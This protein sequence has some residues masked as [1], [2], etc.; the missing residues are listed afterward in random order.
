ML[1]QMRNEHAW[2]PTLFVCRAGRW[3]ASLS[4]VDVAPGSRVIA[5][6]AG[7]AYADVCRR[8]AHGD[9]LDLGCGTVPCYEMYRDRVDTVTCT[10]WLQS[11]HGSRHLDFVSDLTAELPLAPRTFDTVVLT[12]VLEHLP[13]PDVV[14][15]EMRRVL[16]PGGKAIIAVPFL[17]WIHEQPHDFFRYTEHQLRR[18]CEQHDLI[19]R[20][21][22]AYG[23][24]SGVLADVLLKLLGRY[25]VLRAA[26]R[27]LSR[28][29]MSACK[30]TTELTTMPLGYVL[31]AQ[32]PSSSTT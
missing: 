8:H 19:A 25:R 2:Q 11:L 14:L 22:I 10:D 12:D 30:S 16:R 7:A 21:L 9:L 3:Q 23:G 13:D 32:V 15:A 28:V 24:A 4:A 5:S 1:I 6:L 17:Y 27:P 31:V 18:F 29:L 20:E 26:V